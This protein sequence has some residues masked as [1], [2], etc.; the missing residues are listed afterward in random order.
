MSHHLCQFL[1]VRNFYHQ[2]CVREILVRN[3]LK[4]VGAVF[5]EAS[6]VSVPESIEDPVVA[7]DVNVNGTMNLLRAS[8]NSGIKRFVHAS[9]CAVYGEMKSL[10][11]SARYR[12]QVPGSM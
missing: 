5:H 4:D 7:N 9:S 8:L 6:V 2:H 3:I 11:I 10:P 12:V 1:R